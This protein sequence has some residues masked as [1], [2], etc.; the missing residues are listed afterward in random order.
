MVSGFCSATLLLLVDKYRARRGIRISD[1]AEPIGA[2]GFG[3]AVFQGFV[4]RDGEG[5]GFEPGA[6]AA[7]VGFDAEFYGK[8]G[9]VR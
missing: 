4:G 9:V 2:K 5:G 8:A 3:E 7:D 6:F 1:D